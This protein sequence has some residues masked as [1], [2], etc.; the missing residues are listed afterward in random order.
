MSSTATTL[1]P[2]LAVSE[3]FN[4]PAPLTLAGLRGRPVLLHTFQLLCPG[5]VAESIP[6]VQRIERVFQSRDGGFGAFGYAPVGSEFRRAAAFSRKA[7]RGQSIFGL[8]DFFAGECKRIE[9]QC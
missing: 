4:T 3:W 5:C 2:E 9:R 1:A 8:P 7:V 6:Q